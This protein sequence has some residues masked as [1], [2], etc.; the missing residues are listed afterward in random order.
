[1]WMATPNKLNAF[2]RGYNLYAWNRIVILSPEIGL[3]LEISALALR[4]SQ[5]PEDKV[6]P[7]IGGHPVNLIEVYF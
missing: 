7:M 1:M 5:Y 3:Y 2:N 4:P 6:H